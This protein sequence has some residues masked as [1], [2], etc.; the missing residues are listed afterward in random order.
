MLSLGKERVLIIAP[1]ADD[2]VLGCAGL[3][4][5]ASRLGNSV[6]VVV[7]AVGNTYMYHAGQTISADTRKKELVK[8]VKYLGC[9]DVQVLYDDKESWLDT[10][11]KREIISK[12]DGII[13]TFHPTMV[14]I[15]LPGFHQDHQ[16]LYE[17]CMAAMRPKPGLEL[18]LIAMFEYPLIVW[19]H[20]RFISIGELYLDISDSID[21]KIEALRKHASQLRESRDLISEQ[22]V[23]LL[24]QFRGMEAGVPFAEKFYIIRSM[25]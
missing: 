2:E 3:I 12:I 11:P 7:G 9:N 15:P 25:I 5:K 21:K 20:P 23:K 8:A 22:N 4:E 24:A 14:F 17:A 16:Q 13:R 18:K 10:V 19:K 6:K 1:H